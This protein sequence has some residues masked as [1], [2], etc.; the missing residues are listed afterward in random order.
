MDLY[1]R[2]KIS[3]RERKASIK[4]L[5]D[6]KLFVFSFKITVNAGRYAIF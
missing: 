5:A 1:L 2:D 3:Q 4:T 6:F